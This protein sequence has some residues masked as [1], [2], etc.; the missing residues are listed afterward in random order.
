MRIALNATLLAPCLFLCSQFL[1]LHSAEAQEFRKM[2]RDY[3][4]DRPLTYAPNDPTYR[5]KVFN[6]HMGHAGLFHNCDGEEDKRNSPYICWKTHTELDLPPRRGLWRGLKMDIAK[7]QQRI[8]DGAGA[9]CAADCTCASCIGADSGQAVIYEA[10]QVEVAD[11]GWVASMVSHSRTGKAVTVPGNQ[12]RSVVAASKN[13]GQITSRPVGARRVS[14]SSPV[15]KT[16]TVVKVDTPL[17]PKRRGYGLMSGASVP[18]LATV[19]ETRPAGSITVRPYAAK[20][21]SVVKEKTKKS[22][23]LSRVA[24][25]LEALNNRR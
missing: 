9:C 12:Q 6:L 15:V 16:D 25:A 5:G 8:L 22:T 23:S 11:T 21:N 14:I 18:Q 20:T 17:T 4:H 1:F 13:P 24:K 10:A 7:V 19:T 2:L 3:H